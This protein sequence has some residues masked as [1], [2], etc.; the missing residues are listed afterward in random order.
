MTVLFVNDR[1]SVKEKAEAFQ[2][3]SP[4]FMVAT[5]LSAIL[6]Q[7]GKLFLATLMPCNVSTFAAE[8]FPAARRTAKL[9]PMEV[10]AD[11][12]LYPSWMLTNPAE[13]VAA[14]NDIRAR[15]GLPR[16]IHFDQ[17]AAFLSTKP[18]SAL[19][20]KGEMPVK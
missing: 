8:W 10:N 16:L 13:A 1:F 19:R 14:L 15:A 18:S 20:Q 12:W 4:F 7:K 17:H 3:G 6:R 5:K 11:L 2:V 9:A